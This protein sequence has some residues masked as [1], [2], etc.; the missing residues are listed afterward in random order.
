M[1]SG[2]PP[3]G[4]FE[5]LD[6]DAWTRAIDGTLRSALRLIRAALPHLR[7]ER[8]TGDPHHPV[9]DGARAGRRA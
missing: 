2:G 5:D 8:S 1:N 4:D 9:V 6:E 7:D 3:P